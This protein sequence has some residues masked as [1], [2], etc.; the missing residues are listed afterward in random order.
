MRKYIN[1]RA[2]GTVKSQKSQ[3]RLVREL[4][5][6]LFYHELIVLVISCKQR[7]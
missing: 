4:T 1:T 2:L 5:I 7:D 3:G 6:R